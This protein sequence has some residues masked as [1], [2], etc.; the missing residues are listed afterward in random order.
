MPPLD[1]LPPSVA[2]L[3]AAADGAFALGA[4]AHPDLEASLERMEGALQR[5]LGTSPHQQKRDRLR[6][7]IRREV[8]ASVAESLRKDGFTPA[9]DMP[10]DAGD[11]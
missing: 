5:T 4:D 6:D 10:E 11:E 8:S 9:R 3:V 1:E 7:R 2:P